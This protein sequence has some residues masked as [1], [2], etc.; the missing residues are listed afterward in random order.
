[1]SGALPGLESDA[2]LKASAVPHP[3]RNLCCLLKLQPVRENTGRNL[4]TFSNRSQ[5]YNHC[6][7]N[8]RVQELDFLEDTEVR[9]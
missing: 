8:H 2:R 5:I 7:S 9:I 6:D 3:E 1:M 4:I